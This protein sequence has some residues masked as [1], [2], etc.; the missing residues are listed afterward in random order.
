MKGQIR[1]G[2]EDPTIFAKCPNC[3]KGGRG[4]KVGNYYGRAFTLRRWKRRPKCENCKTPLVK[5]FEVE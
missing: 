5:L 2:P 4:V 3:S 1:L